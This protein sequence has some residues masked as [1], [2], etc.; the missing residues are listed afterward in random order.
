MDSKAKS[1]MAEFLG[2]SNTTMRAMLALGALSMVVAC[3][4]PDTILPGQREDVRSVLQIQ[5][6]GD[7]SAVT[8]NQSRPITLPAQTNNANWPQA[9]GTPSLRITHPAAGPVQQIIWSANIGAG[10]SRKQRITATPVVSAGLI[11]TL[12]SGS[13]V[14]ATGTN[15]ARVWSA[16]IRPVRDGEGEATGGGLAVEGDTLYVSLGYG[17]LVAL[18][19]ASGAVKWRQQLDATGSGT[20]TVFGD[21]VYVTAGDDT[22]WAVQ[23][24]TGR[25]VWQISSVTSVNNVLGAPAPAVA[26]DLVLFGFGSGE[27]QAA[28]R[29]GGL[30]RWDT[31]VVGQ[32]AGRALSS[33]NDVT[34]APMIVGNTVYVGNQS[35]RILALDLGSGDRIWTAK[36]G[37][38]D[39]LLV[40]GGSVFA[41]SDLNELLRLDARDGSRIWSVPLPRFTK[42]KPRQQ[43]QIYAHHG[44][45]LAGGRLLVA[46]GDGLLRSFNPVDGA[47]IGSVEIPG[48]AT[49]APVVAGGVVYLV[50]SAGQLVALR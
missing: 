6:E 9:Q 24:D 19:A 50:S 16:D 44:P 35:G 37:A 46:S 18:D 10:D 42:D 13:N 7:V 12:D 11:Y 17:S 34:A 22:G 26:N 30:R 8:E 49:T 25:V 43:S 38:V 39:T 3:A 40:A 2:R 48:G 20:P 27:V 14:T 33:V 23:K 15:G 32:R 31:S 36:E 41:I 4:E 47:L 5:A 1:A 28:F 45:V 29:R 21:L